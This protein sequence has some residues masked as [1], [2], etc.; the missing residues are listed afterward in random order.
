[1]AAARTVSAT[2]RPLTRTTAIR[3]RAVRLDRLDAQAAAIQGALQALGGVLGG[4]A[5]LTHIEALHPDL[6]PP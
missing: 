6:A 1:L 4:H 5:R 3:A 2:L